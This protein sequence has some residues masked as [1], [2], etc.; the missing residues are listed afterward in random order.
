MAA[1]AA[2]GSDFQKTLIGVVAYSAAPTGITAFADAYRRAATFVSG[3]SWRSFA[4]SFSDEPGRVLINSVH[5]RFT[6]KATQLLPS[7][8]ISRRATSGRLGLCG[9]L[10]VEF[11]RCLLEGFGI[12]PRCTEYGD[13]HRVHLLG[14]TL[15]WTARLLAAADAGTGLPTTEFS[16]RRNPRNRLFH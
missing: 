8:G 13:S 10:R 5:V 12:A 14:S 16:L 2:R 3:G 9:A 15:G 7:S 6:P 4:R 11:E 1:G